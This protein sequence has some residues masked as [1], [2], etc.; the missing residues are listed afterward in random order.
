MAAAGTQG[1]PM[2]SVSDD[3]RRRLTSAL[4]AL[5]S[6]Q[7]RSAFAFAPLSPRLASTFP[8]PCCCDGQCGCESV[9]SE[10][11]ICSRIL[12]FRRSPSRTLFYLQCKLRKQMSKQRFDLPRHRSVAGDHSA[13]HRSRLCAAR[14]CS[15]SAV[16]WKH[17]FDACGSV[18]CSS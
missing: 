11:V 17:R 8:F 14:Q 10:S 9:R 15:G 16:G 13:F 5:H 3:G 1:A 7:H 6:A 2:L 18:L 12:C 4:F